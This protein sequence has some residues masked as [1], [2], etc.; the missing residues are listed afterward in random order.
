MDPAELER[1]VD[2]ALRA[3]P[4]PRAPETLA[5]RVMAAVEWQEAGA[6]ASWRHW[7]PAWRALFG[8]ALAVLVLGVWRLAD[9]F[10]ARF[11]AAYRHVVVHVPSAWAAA[12][13]DLAR[14]A[15]ACR[16]IWHVVVQPIAPPLVVFLFAMSAA[17]MLCLIALQRIAFGGVSES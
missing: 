2:R 16:V 5:A 1:L 13:A 9:A 17:A 6:A 15:E 3:L 12:A 14:V 11:E 4:D 10:G 7:A 8:A